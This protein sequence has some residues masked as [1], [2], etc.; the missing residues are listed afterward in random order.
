[1]AQFRLI[2][3][4]KRIKTHS[5]SWVRIL[6]FSAQ[7]AV[8]I[9]RFL[10]RKYGTLVLPTVLMPQILTLFLCSSYKLFCPCYQALGLY[11]NW[12]SPSQLIKCNTMGAKKQEKKRLI[13]KLG[14]EGRSVRE[15]A[16][17]KLAGSV[18]RGHAPPFCYRRST[19]TEWRICFGFIAGFALAQLPDILLRT[20]KA[21]P[22]PGKN[23]SHIR[24]PVQETDSGK[25]GTI[26]SL[27][28]KLWHCPVFF[29]VCMTVTRKIDSKKLY[30]RKRISRARYDDSTRDSFFVCGIMKPCP[31]LPILCP[32]RR[33]AWR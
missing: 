29:V 28:T 21:G 22:R 14:E 15:Q 31:W 25:S 8:Q 23:L 6:S 27:C 16:V 4:P 17:R 13:R 11:I 12:L 1:M 32:A 2:I 18:A 10:G 26:Y 20:K 7:S 19:W 33:T 5:F 24:L 30:N 3:T 9:T